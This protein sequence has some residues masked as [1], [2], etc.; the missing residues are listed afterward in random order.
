MTTMNSPLAANVNSIRSIVAILALGIGA[1]CGMA[2]AQSCASPI[3]VPHL[4]GPILYQRNSCD[5]SNRT[6]AIAN[7]MLS[8]P[9]REEVYKVTVGASE[10]PSF[11]LIRLTP[12]AGT[13]LA[14]SVCSDPCGANSATCLAIADDFDAGIAEQIILSQPKPGDYYVI[15]DSKSFAPAPVGCGAYDLNIFVQED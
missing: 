11:M 5:G 1:G 12:D 7:G 15:V 14:V 4:P 10:L 2:Q 13:D 3:L 6:S 8:M 9:G